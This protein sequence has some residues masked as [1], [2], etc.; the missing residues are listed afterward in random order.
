MLEAGYPNR[1][2]E[3]GVNL[4][5]PVQQHNHNGVCAWPGRSGEMFKVSDAGSDILIILRL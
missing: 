5:H 1:W 2:Q 3:R 4:Q